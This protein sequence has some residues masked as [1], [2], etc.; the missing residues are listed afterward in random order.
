MWYVIDAVDRVADLSS[1]W[2]TAAARGGAPQMARSL[3]IGRPIWAFIEGEATRFHYAEVFE[4]ARHSGLP[5]D[6]Q[7]RCDGLGRQTLLNLR[8]SPLGDQRLRIDIETLREDA[9]QKHKLWDLSL[10]RNGSVVL[11]CSWCSCIEHEG[12]WLPLAEAEA[13]REDLRSQCPPQVAFDV[14]PDCALANSY[15]R[16]T[17][18]DWIKPLR[19]LGEKTRA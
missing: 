11:A 4:A 7:L 5:F 3:V 18:I 10:A 19:R 15:S 14:C 13:Q 2:E 17:E 16:E 8:V 12:D 1:D 6:L 9:V